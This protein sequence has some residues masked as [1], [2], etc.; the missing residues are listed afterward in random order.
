M[1]RAAAGSAAGRPEVV[2]VSDRGPVTAVPDGERVSVRRRPGSLAATLDRC[3]AALPA[4][5]RWVACTT[6][7]ADLRD[8]AELAGVPGAPTRYRYRP[9]LFG[10]GEYRG[11]YDEAG[12]RLLWP[13]LHGTTDEVPAGLPP[14]RQPG[15]FADYLRVNRRL[16]EQVAAGC[17]TAALVS[18]HDYQVAAA[19]AVLRRIRPAQRSALFLHTPFPPPRELARLP[20]DVRTALVTG[21]LGAD[22][23][24]FQCAQWAERF[25]GCCQALGLPVHRSSGRVDRDG[26]PCWVRVYP[27]PIA[28]AQIRRLAATGA[29]LAGTGGRRLVRVDRLDPSKNVLRGFAAFELLLDRSPELRGSVHFD[30]YLVPSRTGVPEYRWYA[31]EVRAAVAA[32][33]RRHPG[34]VTVHVGDDQRRAFAALR[35]YDVLL[36]NAVSDG[37]NLVAQEGPLVNETAGVLVLSTATGSADLLGD[38]ALRLDRP[39][40]VAGTAAALDRALRMPAAER[41]RRAE[42]LRHRVAGGDPVLWLQS[43]LTDLAAIGTAG[44]PLSAPAEA[45]VRR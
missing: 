18:F 11:Y 39:T 40:D 27:V 26:R 3:A 19:P 15:C 37:M 45:P 6:A 31:A 35:R 34:S 41:R 17:G 1:N 9:V 2:L 7:A 30:A 33:D 12:A 44:E 38:A 43:Q 13:A 23:L 4:D 36:V 29:D 28:A 25:L 32:L 5:V 22:L 24:G 8:W 21:M 42:L 16:A 20:V 10:A 14:A